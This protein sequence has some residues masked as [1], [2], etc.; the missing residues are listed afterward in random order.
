MRKPEKLLTRI[1]RTE[2]SMSASESDLGRGMGLAM[3][4]RKW[5]SGLPSNHN[6][7]R[8]GP[9]LGGIRGLDCAETANLVDVPNRAVDDRTDKSQ[10]VEEDVSPDPPF[11]QGIIYSVG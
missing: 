6:R 3:I 1:L 4:R 7:E 2:P 11:A 8:Q 9:V 5:L 10:H